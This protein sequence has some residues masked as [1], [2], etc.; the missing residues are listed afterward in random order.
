MARPKKQINKEV[1]EEL[2]GIQC[3]L[4]E[5]ASVF[6]CHIDTIDRFCKEEYDEGFSNVYKKYS[7][8]GK[9]SLRRAQWKKG[10]NDHHVGMLIWL[11]KQYLGQTDKVHNVDEGTSNALNEIVNAIQG[12]KKNEQESKG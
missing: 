10:V 9:T 8:G 7:E 2:C 1:F 5:I 3:T 6:K 4:N 12:G 11:G